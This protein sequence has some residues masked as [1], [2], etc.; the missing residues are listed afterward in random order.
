ML[1]G[2]AVIIAVIADLPMKYIDFIFLL[3][4]GINKI[5]SSSFG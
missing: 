4:K 5:D 2:R 3:K 1:S